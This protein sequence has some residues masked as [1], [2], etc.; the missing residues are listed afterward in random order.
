MGAWLSSLHVRSDNRELVRRAADSVAASGGCKFFLG[1]VRRG[2]IT[3][4]ADLQSLSDDSVRAFARK[5]RAPM[6]YCLVADDDDFRY[7][8][9]RDGALVDRYSSNPEAYAEDI[10]QNERDQ[11]RGVPEHYLDLLGG[12]RGV[13][14]CLALLRQ[15]HGDDD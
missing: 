10:P 7:Q 6:F 14:K 13:E 2:W 8:F 1:P 15:Q 5:V 3:L 12:I 11:W 4:L 9:F